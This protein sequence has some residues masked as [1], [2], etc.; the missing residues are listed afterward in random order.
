M[1][2][3][4]H[5]PVIPLARPS[6]TDADI[7]A[8]AR[9]L[10]TGQLV[11][12][13]HVAEFEEVISRFTNG[14]EIVAVSNCTAALQL[15]LLALGIGPGD[16]VGVATLSW[17]ATANAV[18]L[19]GAT[20]VF[21]DIEGTTLGMDPDALARTIGTGVKLKAIIPV[22]AFGNMA[23]MVA[24]SAIAADHGIPIVEDAACALGAELQGTPAG[25]WGTIG[26]YSF[27]PRKAATTGEGGALRTSD[28]SLARTLRM[29]RNHGIQPASSPA[30]FVDAGF[31]MRLTE[32][33]AAL[34]SSQLSRYGDLLEQRRVLASRYDALLKGLPVQFPASLGKGSHIYQS[35]VIHLHGPS[36]HRRNELIL[37]LKGKGV[38]TNIGTHHMPLLAY[39]RNRFGH[40]SGDFPNTDRLA[41]SA[42]ALPLYSGLGFDQQRHVVDALASL[43]H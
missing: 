7:E 23:N 21:V 4:E 17:P 27:H 18:V 13:A 20:P 28:A 14:G 3:S 36:A 40:A 22:H 31:N 26:C 39:Y 9:V 29:L 35:Y 15:A 1:V 2:S 16:K 30:E 19:C 24:I 34:G 43:L 38:E 11:Q 12:G 32:F 6:I 33:Q 25:A 8:V 41:A 37:E 42:L 10:R 5:A